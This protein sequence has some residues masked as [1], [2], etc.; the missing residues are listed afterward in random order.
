[1]EEI[2]IRLNCEK[3]TQYK[4]LM[5]KT[6]DINCPECI[7]LHSVNV[8]DTLKMP[9]NQEKIKRAQIE[10]ALEDITNSD[11]DHKIENQFKD[12]KI[13]IDMHAKEM[14][15]KIN[16][17]R[18][19]LLNREEEYF[20]KNTKKM[21][22]DDYV[23]YNEILKTEIKDIFKKSK[24]SKELANIVGKLEWE[25]FENT[26]CIKTLTGHTDS[27]LCLLTIDQNTIASGSEDKTIKIWNIKN[28]YCIKTL[29]GHTDSVWCLLSIDQ[30]TIASGSGDE[31]VKIWKIQNSECIKTLIGHTDRRELGRNKCITTLKGHIN[32]VWCLLSIDQNTIASGSKDKTI[33]IW[34]IRYSEYIKTLKGH[35][36]C[37]RC[38][39][40]INQNTLASGSWDATI[41]I[42][43][44]QNSECIKTLT[45]HT[46]SVLCLL[47][48]DQNTIV[49]G[50]YNTIKIWN[51]QNSDCIKTLT[52]HTN[53][54][55]I[56]QIILLI[57]SE[58]FITEFS[59]L[60]SIIDLRKELFKFE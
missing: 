43:N 13:E 45:G 41:K 20:L 5:E 47:S 19:E 56:L 22:L 18:N 36:D 39:L 29:T 60:M 44:I 24:Y 7:K 10:K 51:I 3:W 53:R 28:S 52:G 6:G 55:F 38:L 25:K 16:D 37:V 23:K 33:K 12:L 21:N 34:N 4:N 2:T 31:T 9:I 58:I 32:S 57:L 1:M 49:S 30:N 40:S 59:S 14:K 26:Q 42:W 17:H 46:N 48:I 54:K 15:K 35:T 8:E 11:V 50:S 27:V